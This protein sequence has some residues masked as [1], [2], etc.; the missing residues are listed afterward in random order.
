[1]CQLRK[2]QPGEGDIVFSLISTVLGEYGLNANPE[3]TDNDLYHI[4]ELYFNNHGIFKVLENEGMIIGSY[5]LFRISDAVCELRKMYLAKE[6]RGKGLG[7]RMME[8]AFL[9]AKM[10]G[11]TKMTLE[12]NRCLKEAIQLYQSFGFTE[13][14]PCHLSDRCDMAME[15]TL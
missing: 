7:K 13:C 2:S 6:C 15:K 9:E 12:T 3:T 11:Y 5:G 1:M 8:D 10:L 14:K 4:D